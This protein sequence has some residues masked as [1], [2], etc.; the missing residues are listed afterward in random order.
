VRDATERGEG[1]LLAFADLFTAVLRNGLGEYPAALAAAQRAS[2]RIKLGFVTRVLPELIEAAVYSGEREVAAAALARLRELTYAAATDWAQGVQAYATALVEGG[3]DAEARFR[4]ALEH[5]P[6]DGRAI[7]Y[8]ARAQL[9]YG[10]WLS[11]HDRRREA[12]EQLH[13]AYALFTWMGAEA[14][15]G[16]AAGEL[17]NN[18]EDVSDRVVRSAAQLTVREAQIAGLA[19]DGLSNPEIGAQLFISPRTVEYHLAKVFAKLEI[20][21]RRELHGALPADSE[22]PRR[23]LA[24]R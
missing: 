15:A 21:S 22:V 17:L 2:E 13:E 24:R 16:R 8:R 6:R 4:A 10:E 7:S 19:R 5:L 12:R 23:S 14:F 18:G 20:H 9:L 11:R 1:L 3:E